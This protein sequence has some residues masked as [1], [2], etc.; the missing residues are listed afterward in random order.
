MYSRCR[1]AELAPC[2][3]SAGLGF[4]QLEPTVAVLIKF[5]GTALSQPGLGLKKGSWE[6]GCAVL[7]AKLVI[8]PTADR[9]MGS[10]LLAKNGT[11]APERC[12]ACHYM[13]GVVLLT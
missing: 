2:T 12:T 10:R 5:E 11:P 6:V 13:F 9:A 1:K 8:A 7:S 3:H 4:Q